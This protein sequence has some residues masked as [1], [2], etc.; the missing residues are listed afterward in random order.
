MLFVQPPLQKSTG[1]HARRRVTLEVHEISWQI[2]VGSVKEMVESDFEQRRQRGVSGQVT[3]NIGV[4]FVGPDDHSRGVPAHQALDDT[5][6]RAIAREGDFFLRR[7]GVD[8]WCIPAQRRVHA[9]VRS[10]FH[11][12]FQQVTGSV[13][14]S[15]VNDFIEGFNP[16]GSLLWVEIVGNFYFDF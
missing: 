10:A 8:V 5:F 4:V 3:A 6:H 15:L 13:G 7:D 11:E 2:A 12:A 14:S 16:F 1:I 9:Q